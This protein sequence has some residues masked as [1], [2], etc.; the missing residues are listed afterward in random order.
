MTWRSPAGPGGPGSASIPAEE[1]T[2]MAELGI[3][4]LPVGDDDA[5]PE[6]GAIAWSPR[7]PARAREERLQGRFASPRCSGG[8]LWAVTVI[9]TLA[10]TVP[11]GVPYR[12]IALILAIE[13]TGFAA[14]AIWAWRCHRQS[15]NRV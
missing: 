2:A 15:R 8:A 3:V 5:A 10:I 12:A 7:F 9:S 1:P 14:A 4:L 6:P 13:L 11:S